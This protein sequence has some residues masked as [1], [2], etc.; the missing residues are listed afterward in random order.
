MYNIG[1][2]NS[3]D[4]GPQGWQKKK[5][6]SLRSRVSL[7]QFYNPL[8]LC[9]DQWE[10]LRGV[11]SP[12]LTHS[13]SHR[14][15][16]HRCKPWHGGRY[17]FQK[18]A[19]GDWSPIDTSERFPSLS[20]NDRLKLSTWWKCRSEPPRWKSVRLPLSGATKAP[21]WRE[22]D[23]VMTRYKKHVKKESELYK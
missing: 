4:F 21:S 3:L 11:S 18:R 5:N 8:F 17:Q 12:R 14:E 15:A 7:R 20:F 16:S 13:S 1:M 9:R 6:E 2:S 10:S 22:R 19:G 23:T